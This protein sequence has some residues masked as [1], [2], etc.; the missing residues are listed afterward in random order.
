M[1]RYCRSRFPVNNNSAF[2]SVDRTITTRPPETTRPPDD[3]NIISAFVP[4][5][6]IIDEEMRILNDQFIAQFIALNTGIT[7]EYADTI[8]ALYETALDII[9]NGYNVNCLLQL[10]IIALDD[11]VNSLK[12]PLQAAIFLDSLY[13]PCSCACT[14]YRRWRSPYESDAK[15]SS[16]INAFNFKFGLLTDVLAQPDCKTCN[17]FPI[18][19]EEE[20][21]KEL[22]V[23]I[24][25]RRRRRDDKFDDEFDDKFDDEFDNKF[26][27]EFDRD[28]GR[29]RRRRRR[30]YT[31]LVMLGEV[32]AAIKA[33]ETV[34]NFDC[35]GHRSHNM[36]DSSDTDDEYGN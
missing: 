10:I 35:F 12:M 26:D 25:Y 18:S 14:D 19:A 8:K 9:A 3:V 27:D 11:L 34:A 36:E 15:H 6:R 29:R 5:L 28:R 30:S 4:H 16:L 23:P 21:E 31:N 33:I 22:E 32:D 17:P 2:M 13:F 24:R 7:P 1:K 20:E